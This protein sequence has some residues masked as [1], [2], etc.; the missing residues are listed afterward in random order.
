MMETGAIVF[1][2]VDADAGLA[3]RRA[4]RVGLVT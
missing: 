1:G 2:T 3:G 4:E